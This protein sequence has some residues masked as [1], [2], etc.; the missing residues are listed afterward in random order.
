VLKLRTIA[1]KE[2]QHEKEK[3]PHH[4]SGSRLRCFSSSCFAPQAE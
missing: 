2:S 4:H 3:H 1:K